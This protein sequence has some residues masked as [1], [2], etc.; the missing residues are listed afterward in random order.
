MAIEYTF[1]VIKCSIQ[2]PDIFRYKVRKE[3]KRKYFRNNKYKKDN[4]SL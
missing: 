2:Q 1:R 3:T 4:H